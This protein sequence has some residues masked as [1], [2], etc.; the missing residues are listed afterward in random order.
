MLAGALLIGTGW[1]PSAA[2]QTAECTVDAITRIEKCLV[3]VS[4][5]EVP[6]RVVPIGIGRP[7]FEWQRYRIGIWSARG[8]PGPAVVGLLCP[9]R[10]STATD[11]AG[12]ETTTRLLGVQYN[13][14]LVR[15]DTDVSVLFDFICVYPGEPPPEPPPP[16]PSEDELREAAEPLLTFGTNLNPN[17]SIG[18][19]TGLDTWMWCD[20]PGTIPVSVALR[21]WT[22]VAAVEVVGVR[23]SIQGSEDA[24]LEST[25]CGS[26]AEPAASWEP[27]VKGRYQIRFVSTW[28]G[29][30]DLSYAGFPP[31]T[32]PLGPLDVVAPAIDYD[33][34]EFLGV[35]TR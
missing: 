2:A 32:F 28:A 1:A 12:T 27:Q 10:E 3:E 31:E 8:G 20:R 15:L 11:A 26:E 6:N 24:E 7:L 18:G 34:D 33:V 25:S 17:A 13:I 35:L 16:P 23:W 9:V 14:I 30:W 29:T 22:A 4:G 19:I 21:G 5:A